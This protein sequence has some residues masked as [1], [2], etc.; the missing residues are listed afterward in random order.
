MQQGN[1]A[2]SFTV[3]P[4]SPEQFS[5]VAAQHNSIPIVVCIALA[6]W[7][8][9]IVVYKQFLGCLYAET[10]PSPSSIDFSIAFFF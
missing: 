5:T 10:L 8:S 4:D 7:G 9:D 1:G 3:M 2:R 6:Q